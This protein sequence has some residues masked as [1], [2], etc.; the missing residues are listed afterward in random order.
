MLIPIE[1]QEIPTSRFSKKVIDCRCSCGNIVK[2]Q[3][4]AFRDGNRTCGKCAITEWKKS[5]C[6]K[7]NRLTLHCEL[8]TITAV[9]QKVLWKCD[10]GK[11]KSITL[12]RVINGNTK[13]CG[14]AYSDKRKHDTYAR[15]QKLSRDAWLE[16]YPALIN[17]GTLP[18]SWSKGSRI[19]CTFKC[20]C[21]RTFVNTFNNYSIS[22]KCGHCHDL[23]ITKGQEIDGFRYDGN[24]IIVN[25]KS[26]D[27]IELVCKNCG[28][29]DN[30]ITR[31]AFLGQYA[32]CSYCN[33]ITAE[34]LKDKKF[35]R[36]T[37]KD[38]HDVD[39]Y[40]TKKVEWLCE[41]GNTCYAVISNVING[42]TKSCGNCRKN[43]AE[44]WDKNEQEI[45]KIKCPIGIGD[46]PDGGVVPLEDILTTKTSFLARCPVCDKE[47]Y[48]RWE[49]VRL[50]KSLTC[51]C[52]TNRV[53]SGQNEINKF[54]TGFGIDTILEY[55]LGCLKYDIGLP[56]K[57]LLI[58]YNG[59][60]WHSIGNSMKR[61]MNKYKNAVGYGYELISVFEDE[62]ENKRGIIEAM[63]SNRLV[64]KQ[65]TG[66]RPSS[67]EI[68]NI[69]SAEADCFYDKFHYIGKCNSKI[70]Y[71]VFYNDKLISC[72]SFKRPTRQS[73]Y[74]WELSRMV[75]DSGF[76][77]HGIWSKII[78]LFISDHKPT[79]IVSFSDNRLFSGK[80][81]EKIGFKFDGDVRPD[82]YWTKGSKRHHKSVFRKTD[83]EK[84]SG[85][86]ESQ[87]REGQGYNKIWDLGKKRWLL[88]P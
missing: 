82:Y 73:S 8:S 67:V 57:K 7:Y 66:L 15:H 21:S 25:P 43:V 54:I 77:V 65:L 44:W 10:C 70:N 14:C 87:L 37:I 39:K 42:T 17:D 81:Y 85:M 74:D 36:L 59:L 56:D 50:G 28:H 12:H 86:T 75:S 26:L 24:D 71:G 64:L 27:K 23:V 88:V 16:L 58:E 22:R 1:G 32:R 84:L 13:S 53:S 45:R 4:S 11:F 34:Q 80:V 61:D 33:K 19:K 83:E 63:V 38:P 78:K 6:T 40:S 48:P 72:A 9:R 49:S 30:F 51:G 35:G 60:H 79:S 41:C 20:A 69:S 52:T 76:R 47:Y 18:E 2:I 46:V 29:T 31:Y 68:K 3:W 5:G 55:T 62:W